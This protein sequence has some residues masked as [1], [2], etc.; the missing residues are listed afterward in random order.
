VQCAISAVCR[1][2]IVTSLPFH[3]EYLCMCAQGCRESGI[4]CAPS[5]DPAVSRFMVRLLISAHASLL[6][7]QHQLTVVFFHF[8]FAFLV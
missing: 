7:H 2:D 4:I 6:T 5:S 1:A 3:V 8:E